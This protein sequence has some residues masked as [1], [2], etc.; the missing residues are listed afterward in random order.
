V[1]TESF[2]TGA[3]T[4]AVGEVLDRRYRIVEL[5][6]EGG[7]GQVYRA[8]HVKLRR[9][10][11][12]KVLHPEI[13]AVGNFAR[14]FEREAIAAARLDHP[15]CVGVSDF[16]ELDDGGCFLVMELVEG[17]S[18]DELLDRETRL[19]AP[20]A[21][22]IAIHVLRG[23]EYAHQA[24]VIHR[25]IKPGNIVLS[26]RDGDPDFAR[27][28]DF[29]IA[30]ITDAD[31]GDKLTTK[32]DVFGSPTYMAPE[33]ALGRTVDRR[34]D[35][36]A[37]GVVLYEML[38]GRPPFVGDD[39]LAVLAQHTSSEPPALGEV[40]PEAAVPAALEDAV[41][42]ALAKDPDR[43]FATAAELGA[44]L[45]WQLGEMTGASAPVLGAG[46]PAPELRPDTPVSLPRADTPVPLPRADTPAP[47]PRADTPFPPAGADATG[48][49]RRRRTGLWVAAVVVGTLLFVLILGILASRG[50]PDAFGEAADGIDTSGPPQADDEALAAALDQLQKGK[51]CNDRKAAVAR[52]RELGD[53]RAIP[54][55]TKARRRM[56]GGIFGIG[57]ENV[58]GCLTK[59]ADAAISYLRGLP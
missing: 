16:G 7:M 27:L 57:R 35:I 58:N 29:G 34:A 9:P 54:A 20:R 25:D 2:D 11:A 3:A 4:L 44:V 5:L 15:N 19:P 41:R 22:H 17:T 48:P 55:L 28:V 59:D 21:A 39:K 45:E 50:D 8:E 10:V 56:S 23:L 37:T 38:A 1:S 32:G 30:K 40:C 51:R 47:L 46:T 36:Y 52:L 12:I 49:A 6:A 53:K 43:R 33:Q 18:L 26:E 42:R 31:A 13:D 24:G 14:R